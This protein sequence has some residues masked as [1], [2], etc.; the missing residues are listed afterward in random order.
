MRFAPFLLVATITRQEVPCRSPTIAVPVDQRKVIAPFR[1]LA[2]S[3]GEQGTIS[4]LSLLLDQLGYHMRNSLHLLWLIVAAA[5][6]TL[7]TTNT[8]LGAKDTSGRLPDLFE[9]RIRPLLIRRCI[10]CHGEN[11]S[12]HGLRIDSRPA[13][14]A[15][16]KNGPA[17]VPGKADR[18][19]L[20]QAVRYEKDGPQMPPTGKLP[21]EEIELLEKWISAGAPWPSLPAPPPR[22]NAENHWSFAPLEHVEPP[23]DDTGWSANPIDAFISDKLQ[24]QGLAAGPQ[25]DS[26]TL[27]RRVYFDLV[28]LPPP[29]QEVQSFV[30]DPSP[31]A[32]E[33]LI[34]RLLDSAQYGE[35]WGRHWL[36][37]ARYSDTQ[38]G[39]VDC[40]IP[41]AYLY[42]DYVID[43]FRSDKPYDLFIREQIAGDLMAAQEPEE[44]FSAAIIATGFVGLSLRNGIFK[45]YHPELIIEDTIDTIGK[46]ILGLSI[47]CARCHDHKVEPISTADYYAIYGIFASSEY[48]F[49]GSELPPFSA[50][51]TVPLISPSQ[52]SELSSQQ[53]TR[54]EELRIQ[55]QEQRA[56]HPAQNELKTKRERLARDVARY[57]Q[58]RRQGR[59][60]VGLR[61]SIDDQDIRIREV[62]AKLDNSVRKQWDELKSAERKAGINRAYAMRDGSAHDVPVQIGGDPFDKGQVVPRGIPQRLAGTPSF[63][64]PTGHSGRLEFAQWLSSPDNPLTPRVAV[65]YI[66][67]FHFGKGIVS[68]VDNFGLG[69]ALPTHPRLL[70][71]LAQEFIE[72]G[73]S[74]KHLHRQILLSNTY[75]LAS[76]ANRSN[77]AVDPTNRW[78]WR[79][80]RRRLDAESIRDGILQTSGGLDPSRPGGHPF[81]PEST[82]QFSQHGPFK[83]IYDSPYRSVYL[84]TQRIQHHPFLAL[85]DGADPSRVTSQRKHTA[86]ALQALYLRNSPFIH[87]QSEKL[88]QRLLDTFSN[89]RKRIAM[90]IQR[91]WSRDPTTNEIDDALH[92]IATFTDRMK[93]AS[94]SL[95]TE[96]APQ[97]M[98]EYQFEGNAQ[99]SSGGAQHG[100]LIGNPQFVPGRVGRCVSLDGDGDYVDSGTTMNDLGNSFT[101]ECWVRPGPEQANYADL[102]GNHLGG[103]RGFVLQQQGNA[104]NQFRGSFGVGQDRWVLSKPVQLET[105]KWQHIALVRTPTAMRLFLNKQLACEV[106]STET[107]QPSPLT[108]RVGLGI[109]IV[110]RSFLGEIDEFRVHRGIPER[111][112]KR[113]MPRQFELAAWASYSRLVFTANEFLY[114][115]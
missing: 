92:Y 19:L 70:D 93:L 34:D 107:V 50:G 55:I 96:V 23:D 75:R 56:N 74:V 42:R 109:S 72:N 82:W 81:P 114:V 108:F 57:H 46:S 90:A 49:S 40:P 4:R 77:L 83:A 100:T 28:G 84:M 91:A 110:E 65:N 15:G 47:R 103:G 115:D 61:T 95:S 32:W 22:S 97:L 39:S 1:G 64:I 17:I 16:G 62:V 11:K 51:E 60:D 86:V 54:I 80:D 21:K 24:K 6:A 31:V 63:H 88:A 89:P 99:D 73:W 113:M 38:G 79:F 13:L 29:W 106:L 44:D 104:T 45:H 33:Q 27:I 66:W 30:K 3:P 112:R 59:S 105:A 52:W 102:F 87:Q 7:L 68:S 58:L 37:L 9:Q 43:S 101:V 53:R 8:A 76:T 10:G 48:P 69:G 18:S 14:L 94:N 85:F 35:R 71:W 20:I 41:Q 78:Y 12:G 98:L 67:R 26:R 25:A 36:D 2:K 5:G 111:Y